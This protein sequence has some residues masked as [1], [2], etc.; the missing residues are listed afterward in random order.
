M[1]ARPPLIAPSILS[2][3]FGRLA[4]ELRAVEAA[5]ADLVHV[6]VM[7][8]HFVPNLTIGPPVVEVV[9]K[10]SRLPVD[11]H[12]M[13]TNPEAFIERYVEAGS[14]W[15]S[16]HAET[17]PHLDRVLHQI[18]EAG[19]E[20]GVVLNPHTPP[21]AIEYVL[22]L[23]H[24]VLVMS[25]NPGFGGQRFI[26]AVLPKIAKIRGWI[27]ARGLECRIQV[28]GGVNPETVRSI[29]EAGADVFVAG[30]AVFRA[31]DYARAIGELRT[32]AA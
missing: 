24:H 12:L 25:V 21:E 29:R 6:D 26:P 13:I 22:D 2:A 31:P 1:P 28:D 19:A 11:T 14:D 5:G 32:L 23:A 7:D 4:E 20:P 3:D 27:D 9:R 15:V 8:G 18:A 17:C 16:V 10:V 30:N